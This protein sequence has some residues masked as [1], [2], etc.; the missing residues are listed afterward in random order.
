MP[1]ATTAEAKDGGGV[2]LQRLVRPFRLRSGEVV[3]QP[4]GTRKLKDRALTKATDLAWTL[5]DR[6]WLPIEPASVGIKALLFK[7]VVRPN[8]PSSATR[9]SATK[10]NE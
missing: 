8:D 9:R 5:P 4:E 2:V 6:L 3:E 7:G 10:G 1:P